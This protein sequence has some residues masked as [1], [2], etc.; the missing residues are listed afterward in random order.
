MVTFG[1]TLINSSISSP[2]L[3]AQQMIFLLSF[4]GIWTLLFLV[5]SIVRPRSS[6]ESGT[7]WPKPFGHTVF[8]PQSHQGGGCRSGPEVEPH[9]ARSAL[10]VCAN[11]P[12]GSSQSPEVSLD[13]FREQNRSIHWVTFPKRMIFSCLFTFLAYLDWPNTV[14]V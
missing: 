8:G 10:E 3:L 2:R 1:R 13:W 11:F 4:L 5:T 7:G 6:I 14:L 9:L 12:P